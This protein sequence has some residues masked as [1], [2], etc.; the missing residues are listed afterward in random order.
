MF[1][2]RSS[3]LS[4]VQAARRLRVPKAWL[5][6]EAQAGRVPCIDADGVFLFDP[7]SLDSALIARIRAQVSAGNSADATEPGSEAEGAK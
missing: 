6:A 5:L 3:L 7:A 2:A 4:V 1:I